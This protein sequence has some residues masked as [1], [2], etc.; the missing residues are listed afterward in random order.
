MNK[1]SSEAV[2]RIRKDMV[3]I[4]QMMGK[5]V[6][7]VD[8]LGKNMKKTCEG[9]GGNGATLLVCA[10]EV[11]RLAER[12]GAVK[13][14][15][16]GFTERGEMAYGVYGEIYSIMKSLDDVGFQTRLL[17]F[18]SDIEM[19]RAGEPEDGNDVSI[20]KQFAEADEN[21]G[22]NTANM[23]NTIREM[24]SLIRADIKSDAVDMVR[25]AVSML[26]NA[27]EEGKAII[28]GAE[29]TANASGYG[30]GIMFIAK[31]VSIKIE[32]VGAVVGL[33][34]AYGNDIESSDLEKSGFGLTELP[35]KPAPDAVRITEIKSVIDSVQETAVSLNIV[36]FNAA[37]E[38]ARSGNDSL[39]RESSDKIVEF[40]GHIHQSYKSCAELFSESVKL[41]EML[42][43]GRAESVAALTHKM[44]EDILFQGMILATQLGLESERKNDGVFRGI[45]SSADKAMQILIAVKH[46]KDVV[47]CREALIKYCGEMLSRANELHAQ[48]KAAGAGGVPFECIASEYDSFAEKI[49]GGI[50]C[51]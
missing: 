36:A 10:A 29:S 5:S 14:S 26:Q 32:A 25:E 18:L 2:G 38:T 31:A 3:E 27:V 1:I 7:T 23:L 19:A 46:D 11:S 13:E 50:D 49:K 8:S 24:V 34:E 20:K 51:L 44:I 16:D 17:R 42:Q 6:Q 47:K 40:A 41:I 12:M 28:S 21:N 35:E 30:K 43:I 39:Y 22:K 15:I 4:S 37:I 33:L 48:A 45:A 9:L